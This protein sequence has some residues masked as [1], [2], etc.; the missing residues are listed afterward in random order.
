MYSLFFD[1]KHQVSEPQDSFCV[2]LPNLN[3]KFKIKTGEFKKYFFVLYIDIDFKNQ[4][5]FYT[6]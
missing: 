2:I 1:E 3:T 4:E 5:F 6:K